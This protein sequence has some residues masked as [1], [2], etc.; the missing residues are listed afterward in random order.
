MVN[1]IQLSL[2][3]PAGLNGGRSSV[4]F[5]G[6]RAGEEEMV[7]RIQLLEESHQLAPIYLPIFVSLVS[8]K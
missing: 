1:R 6:S 2:P 8:E 5:V 7:Q 3:Q 4:G